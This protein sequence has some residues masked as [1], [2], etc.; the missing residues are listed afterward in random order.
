MK[1]LTKTYQLQSYTLSDMLL[2]KFSG[3]LYM[4]KLWSRFHSQLS[5]FYFR[6]CVM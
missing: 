4:C 5:A 6:Y 1:T 3:Y 2:S